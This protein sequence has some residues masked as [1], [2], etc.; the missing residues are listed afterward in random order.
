M[1]AVFNNIYRFERELGKGGFGTVFLAREDVSHRLVAIKQL[2]SQDPARQKAIVHEMQMVSQF[3]HPNIVT[4]HHHFSENDLLFLVMEY[5]A[6]GSVRDAL[7]NRKVSATE[8]LN[9]IQTIA[10]ALDFVHGKKIIHHDIKPDNLLVADHG[11]L[12]ISDFGI[13]NTGA[14]TRSYMSPEALNWDDNSVLDA[15][16]DIYA[17]H[18]WLHRSH[19]IPAT[20]LSI[21]PA[22]WLSVMVLCDGSRRFA[23]NSM[24]NE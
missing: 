9:W 23:D 5:C 18:S 22:V 24:R 15:R 4:Y 16:V 6:G 12:K 7:E 14:G 8:A 1:P 3:N 17:L 13:A 10:E 11:T 19:S 20:K 21:S 2:N